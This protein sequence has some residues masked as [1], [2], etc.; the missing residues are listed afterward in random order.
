[1]ADVIYRFVNTPFGGNQDIT[2]TAD[3]MPDYFLTDRGSCKHDA[4]F[5]WQDMA[6]RLV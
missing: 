2:M 4:G 1:M 3:E 6:I 5:C